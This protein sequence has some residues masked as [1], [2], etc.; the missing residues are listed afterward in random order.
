VH[1]VISDTAG[2]EL[3]RVLSGNAGKFELNFSGDGIFTISVLR[4]GLQPAYS[5][6]MRAGRNERLQIDLLIPADP[7]ALAPVNV[8][9]RKTMKSTNEIRYDNARLRGWQVVSPQ[10]VAA[11]R[12]RT[13]TLDQLIRTLGIT[14][15]TPTPTCIRHNRTMR[16]LDYVLDGQFVGRFHGINPRDID[17]FAILSPVEAL[18]E[19]GDRARNGALLIYTRVSSEG[20]NRDK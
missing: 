17:F 20:Y 15:V 10:R 13:N 12:E 14:T 19:F 11:V 16:C 4:I 3:A 8:I 7:I 6:R 5:E 2:N 18:L 1:V 9:A